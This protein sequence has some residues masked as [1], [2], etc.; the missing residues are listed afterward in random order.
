MTTIRPRSRRTSRSK[1][2]ASAVAFLATLGVSTIDAL[3]LGALSTS[4]KATGDPLALPPEFDA[5]L[6]SD[7]SYLDAEALAEIWGFEEVYDAKIKLGSLL[8]AGEPIPLEPG[9]TSTEEVP[10]AISLA[11]VVFYDSNYAYEDALELAEYWG[12]EDPY[13]AKLKIGQFLKAGYPLPIEPGEMVGPFTFYNEV[14]Y[15]WGDAEDLA[16]Y[17]GIESAN[18]AKLKA[19]SLLE[20]GERLPI[21]SRGTALSTYNVYGYGWGD[22][23]ELADYWG[24]DHPNDAKLKAGRNLKAGY[25]PPN[26]PRAASLERFI[27]DGY[28]WADALELAEY[29]GFE[30]EN[31]AKIKA[32][33]MLKAGDT[34]PLAD[35]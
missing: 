3:P 27:Y 30:D 8:I 21:E 31:D 17:W 26:A 32:G 35:I 1:K 19:A 5:Y 14:G 9:A 11:I 29:W 10:E 15:G 7:Y 24:L 18:D 28:S 33:R 12:L 6:D 23:V 2:A 34:P 4:P 22:A 13:D 25:S 16:D 20:Q